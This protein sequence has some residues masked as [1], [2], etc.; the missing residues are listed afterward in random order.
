MLGLCNGEHQTV[1]VLIRQAL[2]V[3]LYYT[4]FLFA[5]RYVHDDV[6]F[7][8]FECKRLSYDSVDYRC[9]SDTLQAGLSHECKVFLSYAAHVNCRMQRLEPISCLTSFDSLFGPCFSKDVL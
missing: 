4:I 3:Q 1:H 8:F 6:P 5:K 2:Y 9:E 7:L